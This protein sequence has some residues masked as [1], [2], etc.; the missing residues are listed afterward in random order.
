M[1]WQCD[2]QGFVKKEQCRCSQKK[3]QD[4]KVHITPRIMVKENEE[5]KEMSKEFINYPMRK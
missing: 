1:G 4:T 3:K 2:K 5:K